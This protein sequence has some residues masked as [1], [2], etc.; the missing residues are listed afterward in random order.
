MPDLKRGNTLM[1]CEIEEAR[2]ILEAKEGESLVDAAARQMA[3]EEETYQYARQ[4]IDD[5]KVRLACALDRE[6]AWERAAIH[7]MK[8]EKV[9][10]ICP[11]CGQYITDGKPCGCGAR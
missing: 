8:G 10:F 6:R 4:I 9:T 3:R 11:L 1:I 2:E 5:L 7:I